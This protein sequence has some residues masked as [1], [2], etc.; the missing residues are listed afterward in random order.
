MPR[1]ML[2][3]VGSSSALTSG[4]TPAKA[5]RMRVEAREGASLA[6]SVM[7]RST[8]SGVT[9]TLKRF[10]NGMRVDVV[11]TMQTVS[12]GARMSALDGIRQ[13]LITMLLTRCAKM[14]SAPLAGYILMS[15]PARAA[16]PWPQMP[17]A[18][19][20]TGAK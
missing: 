17:A 4:R 20:M 19:T 15:T 11:P 16:M 3:P 14:S 1:E 10:L 18:L 12:P 2:R 5:R 8:S 9:A 6:P 13:R 7:S